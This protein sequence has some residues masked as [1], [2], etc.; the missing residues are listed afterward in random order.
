MPLA[1]SAL[2]ESL[3]WH[4]VIVRRSRWRRPA[5]ARTPGLG[6]QCQW[7][8]GPRP[9]RARSRGLCSTAVTA[10][11]L[12]L[13]VPVRLIVLGAGQVTEDPAPEGP[14]ASLIRV[15]AAAAAWV[16][17]ARATSLGLQVRRARGPSSSSALTGRG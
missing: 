2:S 16:R 15:L 13:A 9:G 5:W 4:R 1:S 3:H 12:P 7:A 8:S 17:V 10:T 11:Q 6:C 14:P